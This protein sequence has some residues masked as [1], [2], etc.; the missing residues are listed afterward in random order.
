M[1]SGIKN[2]KNLGI[3]LEGRKACR[4][5]SPLEGAKPDERS[6]SFGSLL[7]HPSLS[8]L[9]ILFKL[10]LCASVSLWR[11][12][13]NICACLDITY[14]NYSFLRVLRLMGRACP[15]R[16]VLGIVDIKLHKSAP[17]D[18]PA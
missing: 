2:S 10:P 14:V 5:T 7:T 13:A 1:A 9:D 16:W 17:Q 18:G 15:Q 4:V 6:V 12:G 8:S 11:M 3:Q